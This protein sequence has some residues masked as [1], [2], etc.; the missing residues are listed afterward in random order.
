VIKHGKEPYLECSSKGDK[1]FSAFYAK[2]KKYDDMSIEEIYQASK[3]FENGETGLSYKEAEGRKAINQEECLKLYSKLWDEYI[4]ENVNL[5]E[6][7]R[8]ASG[9]SDIFGQEGHACQ[10]TE[11]WRIRNAERV[12]LI[13]MFN[14]WVRFYYPNLD[15][16]HVDP[17]MYGCTYLFNLIYNNINKYDKIY[18]VLDSD[19]TNHDKNKLFEEYKDGRES[20]K[21]LFKNFND[22]LLIIS[23]L[24][25]LQIITNIYREADE[26]IAYIALTK[27][28]KNK[29]IIYSNDKDFIHLKPVSDNITV[30]TNFK[31]GI[32]KALSDDEILDKFKD[33]KKIRLTEN[34]NEIIKWR[35]FI[36]DSSDNI[37]SA[38]KNLP[39]KKIKE[40]INV[41]QEDYL[42]DS[43]L[44][45]IIMRLNDMDLK[46]KIA[47][48]FKQILL[49]YK[50]MNLTECYKDFKLKKFTKCVNIEVSKEAYLN[51]LEKYKLSSSFRRLVN[52]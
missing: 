42:N 12:L 10:A 39:K 43:V 37:P 40:I 47:E 50:L 41:W 21:E 11:L 38:I 33:S 26:V 27:C 25:K 51:L 15:G 35:T 31:G 36:G 28:K 30:S 29:V 5:L 14:M 45:E 46:M 17:S 19:K 2:L 20:K 52:Y 6:V 24:P 44:V 7:L 4:E 22:F 18:V 23:K 8:N 48:K 16:G 32:F 34:I 49:N 9:L 1:R 3:I 13:D